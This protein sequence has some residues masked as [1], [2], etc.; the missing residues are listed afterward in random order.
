MSR[1]IIIQTKR[2]VVCREFG[3]LA[4]WEDDYNRYING[5]LIQDAFPDL[6]TPAREQI[7]SGTHPECWIKL[8]GDDETD[9]PQGTTE[10]KLKEYND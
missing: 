1:Y 8:F 7:V 3:D 2:C 10:N 6:M 4:V 9:R 5:A